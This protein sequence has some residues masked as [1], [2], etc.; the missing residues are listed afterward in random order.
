MSFAELKIWCKHINN[1][2][3]RCLLNF[4]FL[5]PAFCLLNV[6][7]DSAFQMGLIRSLHQQ[8]T[9][10]EMAWKEIL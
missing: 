8:G 9:G 4:C 6:V 2:V 7:R 5:T 1:A 3:I 10:N